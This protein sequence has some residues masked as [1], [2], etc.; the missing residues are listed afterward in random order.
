MRNLLL[1][2]SSRADNPDYLAHGLPW[3]S[4]HFAGKRVLFIPYAGVTMSHETYTGMVQEA[5]AKEN[6]QVT[7][8]QDYTQPAEAIAEA[9]AVAVGGGNTYMLLH[10][11]YETGSLDVLKRRIQE[12]MPYAGW[13]AGSNI[14]GPSIRT[15]N[16]MPII[17]PRSFNAL[18]VVP[19]QLNPHFTDAMPKGHRGE[20]RSQRIAEFMVVDS[21]T[22]VLG[23]MEGTALKVQGQHMQL[24]GEKDGVVFADNTRRTLKAGSTI[25]H[26]L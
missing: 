2:S 20:T 13:S 1:M 25:S 26:W 4:E 6:I 5:L 3:L 19:F 9:E 14:A 15:T 16:D 10:T 12:G 7:G 21:H 22:P 18:N 11:L 17:Q 8:I 23:I 24:L